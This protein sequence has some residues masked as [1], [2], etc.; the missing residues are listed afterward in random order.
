M[1]VG[2]RRER[3]RA[4]VMASASIA[5][6]LSRE[7]MLLDQCC[8]QLESELAR[9]L[10]VLEAVKEQ[11]RS[12]RARDL[13][14]LDRV[15]RELGTMAADGLRA[16]GERQ[17]LSARLAAHFKIAPAE[18]KISALVARVPD[19]WRGRL[20]QTQ[21]TLKETLAIIQKLV[22]SNG[23]FLRDGVRAADRILAD[24]FGA[25]AQAEAYGSDGRQPARPDSVSAVLNVA[26]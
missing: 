6:P 5:S 10:R 7:A 17:A 14:T 22:Q 8:A 24:V 26:G 21:A 2:L 25:P 4:V 13:A 20:M 15:T 19:P 1:D 23:R 16:E 3:E 11:A 12:A 18:V 9:Q